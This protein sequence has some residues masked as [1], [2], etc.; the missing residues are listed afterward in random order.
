MSL[1]TLPRVPVP[2]YTQGQR[3]LQVTIDTLTNNINRLAADAQSF[4]KRLDETARTVA[5]VGGETNYPVPPAPSGLQATGLF[6]SVVLSW[7]AG[8]VE[9]FAYTEIWRSDTDNRSTATFRGTARAMVFT[10]SAQEGQTY[11][12]WIR[13]VNLNSVAGPWNDV[14]GVSATTNISAATVLEAIEGGLTEIHLASALA[15]RIDLIDTPTTGILARLGVTEEDLYSPTTGILERLGIAEEDLYNPTTGIFAL[16][17]SLSDVVTDPVTGLVTKASQDDVDTLSA[18]VTDPVTGLTARALQADLVSLSTTVDGKADASALNSLEATVNDPSTG[19]STRASQSDLVSLS[20]TVDGKA[21]AL[22]LSSLEAV[23]TDPTTGLSTRASQAD[24]TSLSTTVD[25]KAEASTVSQLSIDVGDLDTEVSGAVSQI[26][27]I[28]ADIDDILAEWAVQVVTDTADGT[29]ISGISLMNAGG[30]STFQVLANNYALWDPGPNYDINNADKELV[31]GYFGGQL[32]IDGAYMRTATID[33]AAIIALAVE[34]LVAG[35]L[36]AGTWI[37]GGDF[38]GGQLRLGVGG[39][40]R[41]DENGVNA[42]YSFVVDS[43]G[44]IEMDGPYLRTAVSGE[45]LEWSSALNRLS[46]FNSSNSEIVRIGSSSSGFDADVNVLG[47]LRADYMRT[48]ELGVW[49]SGYSGA[50]AVMNVS[51]ANV[52]FVSSPAIDYYNF[53][54]P[55]RIA[56]SSVRTYANTPGLPNDEDDVGIVRPFF[57]LSQTA[58]Q[59]GANVSGTNLAAFSTGGVTSFF[60]TDYPGSSL[61]GTE[62]GT[63]KY[64]G[65]HGIAYDSTDDEYPTGLFLKIS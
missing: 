65:H 52:N 47:D 63:W 50:A 10:D 15:G 19:L 35:T 22:D 18:T 60:R 7:S 30:S 61:F 37:K 20:T 55:V 21:E 34:K 39:A 53:D 32:G 41:P 4:D 11:Y 17:Q 9:G 46:F 56:G 14:D 64:V 27:S 58:I 54:E 49:A 23:V 26:S 42:G 38:F 5:S 3:N 8:V 40:V 16:H 43:D 29:I 25:G 28:Q 57:Y 36:Q 62:S 12:Y 2:R 6:Q 59:T 44:A 51:G 45:R 48:L 1:K 24:L 31:I 13:H 33:D